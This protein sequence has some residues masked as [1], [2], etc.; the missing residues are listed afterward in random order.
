MNYT[1]NQ[2]IL[3]ALIG[4][5]IAYQGVPQSLKDL[6]FGPASPAL[7][8]VSATALGGLYAL[9]KLKSRGHGDK[10]DEG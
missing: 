1:R 5:G 7:Q 4:C 2:M 9:E 8:V 3:T 10:P 6:A